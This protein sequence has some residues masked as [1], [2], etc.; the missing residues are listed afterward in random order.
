YDGDFFARNLETGVVDRVKRGKQPRR[1]RYL[2]YCTWAH[3]LMVSD[4]KIGPESWEFA[5]PVEVLT[6]I[7]ELVPGNVKGE[8][9]E[10]GTQN[11]CFVPRVTEQFY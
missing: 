5:F 8:I 10:V 1:I 9:R 6:H 3:A 11:N 2:D 4:I 7:R